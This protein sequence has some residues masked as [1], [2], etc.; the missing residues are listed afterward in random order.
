M[1]RGE[2]I[3]VSGAP[4]EF[5]IFPAGQFMTDD[6][7]HMLTLDMAQAIVEEFN[8]RGNEMSIDY[9]HAS[10][11]VEAPPDA[12]V[13]GGWIRALEVRGLGEVWACDVRWTPEASAWI[14]SDPPKYR[15]I[16]PFYDCMTDGGT[17]Y[18]V[19]IKNV[20]LTNNPKTWFCTRLASLVSNG[21][22]M[23]DNDK[24][25]A[26]AVLLGLLGLMAASDETLAAYAKE[27][28]AALRSKLGDQA[29]AAMQLASDGA[30]SV[31][32]PV[33]PPAPAAASETAPDEK[34]MA[35]AA[36]SL[37]A[38][39]PAAVR[40]IKDRKAIE[41]LIVTNRGIIPANARPIL[42]KASLADAVA[43]VADLANVVEVTDKSVAGS[44]A[45]VARIPA[46]VES[47]AASLVESKRIRPE[48]AAK[49]K[50]YM[51]DAN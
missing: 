44:G 50:K 16:S 42:M 28:D 34:T 13:S 14:L 33:A 36:A 1:I 11:S 32:A 20:A 21:K 10:I 38:M 8:K 27:Q 6:G 41:K 46:A 15:Y 47:R 37:A 17:A 9:D 7:P 12:R 40:D 19:R 31:P 4:S 48:D 18:P 23:N 43:Y 29:D 39:K 22:T 49:F 24:L 25:L 45:D 35:S 26:G 30:P 2:S 3:D 51:T 5:M